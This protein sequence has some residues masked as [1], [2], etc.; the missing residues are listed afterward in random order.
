MDGLVVTSSKTSLPVKSVY[1]KKSCFK[2]NFLKGASFFVCVNL[3]EEMNENNPSF[4]SI[5]NPFSKKYAKDRIFP[6]IL[7]NFPLNMV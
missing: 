3:L 1:F 7:H 2:M 4:L 5:F 6:Y